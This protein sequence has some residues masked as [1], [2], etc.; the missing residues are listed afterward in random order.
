MGDRVRFL[1]FS[2]QI[3]DLLA[4]ADLLVSPVRYESYG[5]NVQEALCRGVPAIVSAGAG[6]AERYPSQLRDLLLRDP[7]D[8]NDL[9]NRMFMWRS[10]MDHWTQRVS[11]FSNELRAY[12]WRNMAERFYGFA[13]G[14]ASDMS[15]A[16]EMRVNAGGTN[17]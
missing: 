14:A 13:T 4:A 1:G 10:R 7:E 5:L 17:G 16:N 2:D 9:I 15:E 6:V 8:V 3:P 12:S 11:E